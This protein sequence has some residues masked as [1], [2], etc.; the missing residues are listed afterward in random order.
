MKRVRLLLWFWLGL[1]PLNQIKSKLA[2]TAQC[3]GKILLQAVFAQPQPSTKVTIRENLELPMERKYC[4]PQE[5]HGIVQSRSQQGAQRYRYQSLISRYHCHLT[6]PPFSVCCYLNRAPVCY[7]QSF[8]RRL[9]GWSGCIAPWAGEVLPLTGT[10]PF[11]APGQ[12]RCSVRSAGSP[13]M[14]RA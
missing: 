7:L 2:H 6:P 11:S 3:D 13:N 8:R 10:V 14:W 1:Q 5:Q 9:F 4:L 12:A